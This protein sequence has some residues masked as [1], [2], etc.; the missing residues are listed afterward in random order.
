MILL[1]N[2]TQCKG[3]SSW[4]KEKRYRFIF[5]ATI[6]PGIFLG[7]KCSILEIVKTVVYYLSSLLNVNYKST[8]LLN[9]LIPSCPTIG[10]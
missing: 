10:L 6:T 7:I 1:K 5:M 4:E 8:D 2:G 9:Y 3:Y